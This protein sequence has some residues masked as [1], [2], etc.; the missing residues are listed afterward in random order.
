MP[1]HK[2]RPTY[3]F[4]DL[5]GW[6]VVYKG[7]RYKVIQLEE[8]CSFDGWST[9]DGD[10][11]MWDGFYNGWVAFIDHVEGG[12]FSGHLN[13]HVALDYH[14]D[15]MREAVGGLQVAMDEYAKACC[16]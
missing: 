8:G 3:Q 14:Y 13:A 10:Y 7:R 15:T 4:P 9:D 5:T 1:V 2:P 11:L 16:G 6:N 12:G